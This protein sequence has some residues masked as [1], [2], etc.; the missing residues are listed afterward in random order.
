[1]T[2]LLKKLSDMNLI[3]IYLSIIL[4]NFVIELTGSG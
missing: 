3:A 4:Y 2:R 1:M